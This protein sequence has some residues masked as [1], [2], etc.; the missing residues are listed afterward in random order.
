MPLTLEFCSPM[1]SAF[2]NEDPAGLSG[3]VLSIIR[4]RAMDP[5][6]SQELL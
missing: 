1:T 2:F 4:N 6:H 3:I 5:V